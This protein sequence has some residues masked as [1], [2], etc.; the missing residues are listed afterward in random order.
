VEPSASEALLEAIRLLRTKAL[1]ASY[2][3]AS[4]DP[5]DRNQIRAAAS[6]IALRG[7]ELAL[8]DAMDFASSWG[9]DS[10]DLSGLLTRAVVHRST[11][12]SAEEEGTRDQAIRNALV[13]VPPHSLLAVVEDSC[14]YLIE[15]LQD[16]CEEALAAGGIA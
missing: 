9:T 14:S 12:P 10:A 4:F 7:R 5:R 6:I 2:G 11:A 15:S 8:R 13:Q 1:A 3:V 16:T